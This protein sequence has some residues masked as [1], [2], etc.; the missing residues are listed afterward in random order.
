MK[1]VFV[2]KQKTSTEIEIE[3]LLVKLDSDITEE[4]YDITLDRLERLMSIQAKRKKFRIP[5]EYIPVIA[6]LAGI[7]LILY[8]EQTNVLTSKALGFVSKGRV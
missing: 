5:K 8:Y 3:R 1:N 4:D 2:K 6:N 7:A